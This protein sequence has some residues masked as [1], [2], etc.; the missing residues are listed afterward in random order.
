[1]KHFL[2]LILISFIGFCGKTQN[3]KTIQTFEKDTFNTEKGKLVITFFGHSSLMIEAGNLIIHVDPVS[4]Y[5]KY[6]LQPKAD[7]ILVTHE[8]DD[9]FD[10]D[11]IALITQPQTTIFVTKRCNNLSGNLIVLGNGD[12]RSFEDIS[13]KAVPAYNLVNKRPDGTF[14]HPKGFGNGYLLTV[15]GKRIYIGGDTEIIP[16]M[17]NLGA[18]DIAFLPMSLPY[19]MAPQIVAE[20]VSVIKPKYLYPYHMLDTNPQILLDLMKDSETKVYVRKMK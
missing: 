18:I 2:I 20:C 19:T 4:T 8:H 14:F 11:A 3:N 17:S 7:I 13:I 16:E 15:S 9:H 10:K 1:M 5:A 12:S 6:S